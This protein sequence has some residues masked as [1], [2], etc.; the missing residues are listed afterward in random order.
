MPL[1]LGAQTIDFT[2]PK[3]SNK[4][5]AFVLNKGIKQDTIQ[6]GNMSF[7]GNVKI[8]FP[9][10]EKDYVGIAFLQIKD[11]PA[12]NMVVNKESFTVVQGEDLKY[13][14]S[15]SKENNFLYSIMQE[16]KM[17]EPDTTLYASHFIGL[18]RYAQQLN[19]STTQNVSMMERANVRLYALDQLDIDRLYTSSIW[20]NVIDGLT[21]FGTG[22]EQFG[23]DMVRI[24]ER[25]KSQVVF[26]HLLS[27]LITITGQYGWDDAFDI[28]VS[29]AQESGRIE[30]PKGNVYDAFALAKVKKGTI[31][32]ALKGLKVP[33]EESNAEKT[34]LLFYEPDCENCQIQ[35]NKLI[36]EY[37]RI[38]EKGVRV[39]SI[40]A[41]S[42]K[43]DFAK[44]V[45]RFP[46][47]DSDK[48]CDFEGFGGMNFMNY[49][50]MAT[51]TFFL[52]GADKKIFKRYALVA[53]IDF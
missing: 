8:S 51:P 23:Q 5:Y 10:S 40:S 13:V 43:N 36:E 9:E 26:E 20:Y 48:L 18:I 37:P 19:R 17:P 33:I 25:I 16:S 35:I 34:L 39:I 50:I 49:G 28:I 53:E 45:K 41:G 46:W 29:Y 7:S 15:G 27:N 3:E 32:P 22:Q 12:I 4:E 31:P 1:L 52:I 2:L 38:K 14:F 21:K 11:A 30:A 47:D 6:K 42:Q 24:M 44:D